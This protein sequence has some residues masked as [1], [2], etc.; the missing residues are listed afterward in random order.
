[1]KKLFTPAIA[2]IASALSASLIF[3]QSAPPRPPVVGSPTTSRQ[4]TPR[5]APGDSMRG[6]RGMAGI[7][8]PRGGGEA[9]RLLRARRQLDLTDEQV[10]K[11]E[12][13]A[14]AATPIDNRSDMLRAQADMMDA[15][16]GDGN[17][18]AARAA[19]DKMSR[20]RNDEAIAR[21]K[22]RQDMRAMLT[23][24]QKAKFDKMRG[25]MR[26]RMGAR[27]MHNGGGRGRPSMG[28][29]Q[30]RFGQQMGPGQQMG[31]G[32]QMA[33]RNRQAPPMRPPDGL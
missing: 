2:L 12:A 17:L 7:D 33:P 15:T 3:A 26:E 4:G 20:L 31:R 16:K 24:T 32:Q 18:A 5:R 23:P 27:G 11:L 10:K 25:R 1:M 28:R 29:P 13:L 22:S 30:M 8:D 14:A 19:L 9:S 6:P 21:L